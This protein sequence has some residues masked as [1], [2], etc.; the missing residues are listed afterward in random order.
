MGSRGNIVG[1]ARAGEDFR[2][3]RSALTGAWERS[4]GA[5]WSVLGRGRWGAGGEVAGAA[6][7]G[8]NRWQWAGAADVVG[9]PVGASDVRIVAA[10]LL[11]LVA[12][13]LLETMLLILIQFM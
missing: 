8:E 11:S 2:E 7:P 3:R 5:A 4:A 1:A 13:T 9:S 6:G 10:V 12:N